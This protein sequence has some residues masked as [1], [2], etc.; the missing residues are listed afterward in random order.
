MYGSTRIIVIYQQL[1]D[2]RILGRRPT[3]RIDRVLDSLGGGKV[4]TTFNLLSGFFQTSIH[5]ARVK[6]TAFYA[7][8][9]L[10]DGLGFLKA[11]P[12]PWELSNT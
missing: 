7:P 1:N 2:V 11:L 4:S 5:P 9:D 3:P 6:L 12:A 10:Y 8:Q